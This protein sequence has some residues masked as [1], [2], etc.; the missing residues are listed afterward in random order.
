MGLTVSF[1]TIRRWGL[2]PPLGGKY[3]I[4]SV[5]DK[6]RATLELDVNLKLVSCTTGKVLWQRDEFYIDANHTI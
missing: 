5:G 1:F 6:A 4:H 2:R 3:D